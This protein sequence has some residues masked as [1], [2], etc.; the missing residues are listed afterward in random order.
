MYKSE[1]IIHSPEYVRRL[2]VCNSVIDHT[3]AVRATA[4]HA[5]EIKLI[6]IEITSITFGKHKHVD[7][8]SLPLSELIVD[9]KLPVDDTGI[10]DD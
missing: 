1:Q 7:L 4:Q 8:V 6:I 5:V 10:L 9:L 2:D 3:G